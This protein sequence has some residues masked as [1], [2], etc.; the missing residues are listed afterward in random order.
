V[1]S[2]FTLD[3]QV[4]Q[5]LDLWAACGERRSM[6]PGWQPSAGRAAEQVLGA[7]GVAGSGRFRRDSGARPGARSSSFRRVGSHRRRSPGWPRPG[8]GGWRT[9][10]L[11][12]Q[13]PARP[14]E[15]GGVAGASRFCPP[16]VRRLRCIST[17]YRTSSRALRTCARGAPRLCRHHLRRR[18]GNL[19]ARRPRTAAVRTHYFAGFCAAARACPG[20]R[21][22]PNAALFAPWLPA[23]ADLLTNL[24]GARDLLAGGAPVPRRHSGVG[25][26]RSPAPGDVADS[27]R[28]VDRARELTRRALCSLWSI[29]RC[30]CSRCGCRSPH[31]ASGAACMVA[32]GGASSRRDVLAV[33]RVD[34]LRP[35]GRV[36]DPAV[37]LK[38]DGGRPRAVARRWDRPRPGVRRQAALDLAAAGVRGARPLAD[39]VRAG[40]T[41]AGLF[42]VNLAVH[43]LRPL[44]A[45]RHRR[46]A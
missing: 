31:G 13:G 14:L 45:F 22:L 3:R 34:P 28:A 30:G 8:C 40:V 25:R 15:R 29:K 2:H 32:R 41:A 37:R 20:G 7:F 23:Q 10:R 35:A 12:R 36:A 33:A 42:A 24:G 9:E 39:T 44:A 6:R 11:Q 16:P 19:L 26:S 38:P 43:R 27:L 21:G 5:Y 1:L 46:G 18:G 4:E 17:T